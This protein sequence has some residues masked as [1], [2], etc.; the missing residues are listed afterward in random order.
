MH[1]TPDMFC[2]WDVNLPYVVGI[3]VMVE[4][5]SVRLPGHTVCI[6]RG[7]RQA[8]TLP[9]Q[10]TICVQVGGEQYP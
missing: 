4:R 7:H 6:T 5:H 1:N 10:L 9:S 8:R 2:V 3:S